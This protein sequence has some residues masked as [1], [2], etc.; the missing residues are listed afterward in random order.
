MDTDRR[1]KEAIDK[2]CEKAANSGDYNT[3]IEKY[4]NGDFNLALQQK[5]EEMGFTIEEENSEYYNR[6]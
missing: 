4:A 5:L 6:W 3:I 2:M 1:Q